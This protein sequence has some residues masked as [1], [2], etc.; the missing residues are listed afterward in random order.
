MALMG[1]I[2]SSAMKEPLKPWIKDAEPSK[3]PST[4]PP[5]FGFFATLA[6]LVWPLG[7]L[8]AI[9]YLCDP[10]HRGAGAVLFL[11]AIYSAAVTWVLFFH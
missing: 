8:G 3:P 4:N 5:Y 2:L 9:G 1:A 7:M 6:I 11:I 10:K